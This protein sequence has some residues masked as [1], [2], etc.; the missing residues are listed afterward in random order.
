VL[1]HRLDV[2]G[3]RLRPKSLSERAGAPGEDGRS[4][5]HGSLGERRFS[6]PRIEAQPVEEGL[7]RLDQCRGRGVLAAREQPSDRR[8]RALLWDVDAIV[9]GIEPACEFR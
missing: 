4:N 6:R 2:L 9:S 7:D 5:A 1:A 3:R 8:Q